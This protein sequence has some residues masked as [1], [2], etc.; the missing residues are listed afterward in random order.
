MLKHPATLTPIWRYQPMSI[1][2]PYYVYAYIS[3]RTGLPYYIGKGSNGRAYEKHYNKVSVPEDRIRIILMETGLTEVGA[4]ALERR[5][6]CWYGRRDNGTGVLLNR[7]DGGDGVSNRS[8]ESRRKI[9]LA[10]KGKKCPPVSVETRRKISIALKDKKKPPRTEEHCKKLGREYTEERRRKMSE[11]LKGVK[12]PSRNEE[13]CRKISE[14]MKEYWKDRFDR[15]DFVNDIFDNGKEYRC[16][17]CDKYGIGPAMK[18]WHFDNCRDGGVI[19]H[20]S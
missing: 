19:C 17:H 5:Y 12:K 15:V 2:P 20:S 14:H 10:H 7:T 11:I 8:E 18:R 9:S 4:F 1:Y 16:P 13:Y 3:K 6:I